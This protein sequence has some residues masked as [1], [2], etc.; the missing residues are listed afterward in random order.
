MSLLTTQSLVQFAI[1]ALGQAFNPPFE[2]QKT[3]DLIV[4]YTNAATLADT[5][6]TLNVD[7]TVGGALT[8][9]VILNPTVT[10][11]ATGLHY[12]VGGTLTIQR[13]PPATQPTTYQDG[14]NYLAAVNNT[15]LNWIVYS[16]QALYDLVNRCAQVP[17]TSGVQASI[18]LAIRK[19]TLLGFDANGNFSTY[20][21]PT[22]PGA[23][24]N[25]TVNNNIVG[26]T[27]GGPTHLDGIDCTPGAGPA[28]G[29]I[30][31]FTLGGIGLGH[32]TEWQLTTSARATAPDVVAA[33]NLASARWIQIL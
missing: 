2:I 23:A 20:A 21:Y 4:T 8:A 33:L 22:T 9:G 31:K 15:S 14:V 7:Y 24:T 1:A 16:I 5:L 29:S 26:P 6:L 27:G 17:P 3:S 12:A 32:T 13:K 10:L 25:L 18:P 28:I 11:E 19:S 30:Y